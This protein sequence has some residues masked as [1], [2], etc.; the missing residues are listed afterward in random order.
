[1]ADTAKARY[2]E[3]ATVRDAFLRRAREASAL[4]IPTL[5]PP[6]GHN[7]TSLLPEPNQGFG[8]RVVTHLASYFTSALLPSGRSFFRLSVAPEVLLQSNQDTVPPDLEGKLTLVERIP[9]QEVARRNWRSPTDTSLQHL[10]VAGNVGEQMLEDNSIVVHTLQTYVVV[11]DPA[12]KLTEFVIEQSLT[13]ASTPP[14][15][16]SLY[17]HQDNSGSNVRRCL[18]TW[19]R[20]QN[21]VWNVHQEFEDHP[22]PNSEG[23]YPDGKLPFWFLRW[24]AVAGEDYG[25]GKV[26]LHM[27]DLRTLDG[28]TKAMRDGGAM[29]S[30]NITLVR[31]GA[32]AGLNLLRKI[33]KASNG[34]ML[35]GNPEDVNML[36]FTNT[37]GL[38]IV[39]QEIQ[40]LRQELGAAFMLSSATTRQAERVTAEEIRR[41]GQELDSVQGGA[42][43]MLSQEMMRL[44]VDRLLYQMMV[45]KQLPA[46]PDKMI[47]PTILTGLEALAREADTQNVAQAMMLIQQLPDETKQAYVKWPVMLKKGFNGL[48][49]SDAVNTEEEAQA[50]REARQNA[51]MI[52]SMVANAA[53]PVAQAAAQGPTQ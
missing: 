53:G 10:L 28:L 1:M 32:A 17:P 24:Q 8:A 5:I 29:A 39:Q 6:E 41:V 20:L 27:P 23:Q 25:R 49:L 30:R 9:H 37:T 42:F 15:L 18:Y 22:V 51:M 7:A 47:E 43:S 2:A 34:T 44:R 16:Q 35:I 46:W 38:Q 4:T 13:P 33:S 11:R 31:P 14:E 40:N 50:L 19:G 45:N 3:L 36:Q 21:G 48:D 12:G 26:E 52:Q